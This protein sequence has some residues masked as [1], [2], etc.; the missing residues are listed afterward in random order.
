MGLRITPGEEG[1]DKGIGAR[2]GW[3]AAEMQVPQG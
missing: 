1:R 3:Q 2:V